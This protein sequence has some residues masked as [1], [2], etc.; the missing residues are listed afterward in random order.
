M[1]KLVVNQNK[2]TKEN[3]NELLSICPFN[4]IENHDGKIEVNA[5]CKLCK[6]C[7][8][9]GPKGVMEFV[10]EEV[11]AI[12]K[13][14]WKGILVYVDHVE[15]NIHP[16]TFELIGKAKELASKINHP[17]YALFIGHN[18][19]EKAEELLHYGV[20]EVFVYDYEELKDFSIEPYTAV[21]EDLI[22]K[23]KPTAIL[24][25]ATTV[26]RSLAPRIA[27][28][29]KT[30]LTADCTILDMK[31]NTD[32]VQI[33]PAFGGNIMA[34][35]VNPNS[36]PQMATVRYKVMS[37]PE[38]QKEESGKISL[39]S[40]SKEKLAS[41]IKVLKVTKKLP[42]NSISDA[43]V[44]IAVGRGIKT[45]KDMDMVYELAN[46]LKARVAGTRPLVE[47]G[48]IDAKTQIGLSGRTVKPKLIIV[49]GVSGAVQFT[50]G[51]NSSE[52][53][54]AINKDEKAPIFNAS[55]YGIVGDIYEIVPKLIEE[56]KQNKKIESAV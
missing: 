36:R 26:G 56:L 7:V 42:E 41:N 8:R 43:E 53:I 21:F 11:K 13:S 19:K 28:R 33:R 37:A 27:A 54:F 40:I 25:G 22:N 12:D 4:A 30:G 34:Q 38:R 45:K 1:G 2:V 5:G 24:V 29:F 15:G 35:I 46:L 51:M 50:A 6:M 52:Y 48:W 44:I 20:D 55:H 10:E 32:L 39:C 17:V 31:E 47:A 9:K 14:L 3:I 23:V 18:I 49:L 16:V